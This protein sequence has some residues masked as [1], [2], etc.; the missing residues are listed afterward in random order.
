MRLRGTSEIGPT[1]ESLRGAAPKRSE[2]R[3]SFFQD[4]FSG[5][6]GFPVA[7]MTTPNLQHD[8]V[9][10]S[11]LEDAV[12]DVLGYAVH[13]S[14]GRWQEAEDAIQEASMAAWRKRAEISLLDGHL[15]AFLRKC[16]KDFFAQRSR[17]RKSLEKALARFVADPDREWEEPDVS[18]SLESA[19][20]AEA[21]ALIESFR[22]WLPDDLA[23]FAKICVEERGVRER[24]ERRIGGGPSA[25]RWHRHKL[26]RWRR[27]E[28]Y[29]IGGVCNFWTNLLILTMLSP[30]AVAGRIGRLRFSSA[31]YDHC[32]NEL[33]P[34]MFNA[35][36]GLPNDEEA[37]RALHALVMLHYPLG[38]VTYPHLTHLDKN[39]L[40]TLFKPSQDLVYDSLPV[41]YGESSS[42]RP[43]L[44]LAAQL[45]WLEMHLKESAKH[46]HDLVSPILQATELLLFSFCKMEVHVTE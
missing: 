12:Q 24:I 44:D 6:T 27:D 1:C 28:D 33:L 5:E 8:K 19:D 4:S 11:R 23:Q 46:V 42:K 2:K 37:G 41:V 25:L 34:G 18:A 43:L 10:A 13:R 35:F 31:E 7:R 17:Q 14:Q 29:K 9:F 38:A 32:V 40:R 16:I 39:Q 22:G 20:L 3:K 30:Y 36:E 15:D 21:I 26:R 45:V